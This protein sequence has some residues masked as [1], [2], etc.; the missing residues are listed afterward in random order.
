MEI[1]V[2]EYK[3][4]ASLF[5]QAQ[6]QISVYLTTKV[7]IFKLCS[8]V[9]QGDQHKTHVASVMQLVKCAQKCMITRAQ[10]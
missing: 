6:H 10:T 9:W 8:E 5:S 2:H 4:E 7:C 1:T 3:K